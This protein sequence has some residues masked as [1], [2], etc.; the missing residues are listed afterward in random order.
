VWSFYLQ[1]DA[2]FISRGQSRMNVQDILTKVSEMNPKN[3]LVVS[4]DPKSGQAQIDFHIESVGQLTYMSKSLDC[5]IYEVLTGKQKLAK[6][7]SEVG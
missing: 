6:S 2:L 7:S 3:M 5:L 1:R 4:I